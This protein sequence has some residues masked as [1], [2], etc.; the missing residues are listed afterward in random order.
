MKSR[1]PLYL[2]CPLWENYSLT[3]TLF[4]SSSRLREGVKYLECSH[5]LHSLVVTLLSGRWEHVG[6][7]SF[8]QGKWVQWL[9]LACCSKPVILQGK[10]HHWRD[11]SEVLLLMREPRPLNPAAKSIVNSLQFF[12]LMKHLSAYLRNILLG[13]FFVTLQF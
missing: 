11:G 13:F 3:S 9:L 4:F 1:I 10:F 12:F 6:L 5:R 7:S 2:V 8:M